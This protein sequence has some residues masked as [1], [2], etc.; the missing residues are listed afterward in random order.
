MVAIAVEKWDLHKRL[1][2]WVLLLMGS[3]PSMCVK[4]IMYNIVCNSI[5]TF[6]SQQV[7]IIILTSDSLISP[8]SFWI[9]KIN[10]C[11]PDDPTGNKNNT[12]QNRR[13][14]IYY[15]LVHYIGY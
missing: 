14:I 9:Y 6:I 10:L 13:C 12:L 4:T 3:R 2:L 7:I 8:R 5:I 15:C 11:P 1:A